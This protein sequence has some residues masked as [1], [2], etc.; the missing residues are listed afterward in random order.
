MA[1]ARLL[2]QRGDRASALNAYLLVA[3]GSPKGSIDDS[4][5]VAMRELYRAVKGSDQS[6]EATLDAVHADRYRNPVT[7]QPY[8][9][10]VTRTSRTVL[11][12][13]FTGTACPPCVASDLMLDAARRRYV[14]SDVITLEYHVNVPGPDPMAIA[15]GPA[16]QRYYGR[17]GVPHVAIDGAPSPVAVGGDRSGVIATYDRFVPVIDAA[18]ERPEGARLNVDAAT[19]GN[20]VRIN[21]SVSG[22]TVGARDLRLHIVLAERQIRHQAENGMRFHHMVVRASAA[23]GDGLT[24]AGNTKQSV[25]FELADVKRDVESSFAAAMKDPSA[26]ARAVS[27]VNTSELVAVVFVQDGDRRVLQAASASVVRK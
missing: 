20:S 5:L 23:N 26:T 2:A 1:L 12:E 3:A 19:D 18:L 24:I 17:G 10:S 7:P 14:D 4:D 13:S 27:F 8:R 6:L 16:R 9:R 22:L 11:I 15:A 21:A 25:S